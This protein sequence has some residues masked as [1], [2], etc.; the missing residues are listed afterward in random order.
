MLL[1]SRKASP[2]IR[3]PDRRQVGLQF[4]IVPAIGDRE[5]PQGG[6]FGDLRTVAAIP[7]G[8]YSTASAGWSACWGTDGEE[9]VCVQAGRIHKLLTSRAG[10]GA[11]PPSSGRFCRI[12]PREAGLPAATADGVRA[13]AAGR[14]R[15]T[16]CAVRG[17]PCDE[18][19]ATGRL[20]TQPLLPWRRRRTARRRP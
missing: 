4:G 17:Q 11:S 18:T 7:A 5:A 13:S 12:R 20:P 14:F 1:C 2:G 3:G 10:A 16:R 8:R 19:A 9:V 6:R 15:P